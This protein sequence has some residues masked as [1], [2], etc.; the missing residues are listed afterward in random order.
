MSIDRQSV[1]DFMFATEALLKGNELDE[2]SDA[3]TQA[4]A[5]MLHQLSQRLLD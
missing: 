1:Q 2:L 5:N 4:I 3:E